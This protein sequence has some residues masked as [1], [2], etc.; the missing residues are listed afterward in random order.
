[1]N[2]IESEKID[3]TSL[4]SKTEVWRFLRN[5]ARYK[6]RSSINRSEKREIEPKKNCLINFCSHCGDGV[7]LLEGEM[8]WEICEL[9]KKT[10][11]GTKLNLVFS[12]NETFDDDDETFDSK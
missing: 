5:C 10:E 4:H 12:G 2:T 6:T 9:S 7:G 1:M 8:N 3:K 11:N